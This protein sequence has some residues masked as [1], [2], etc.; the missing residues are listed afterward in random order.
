LVVG[1]LTEEEGVKAAIGEVLVHQQ[2]PIASTHHP[3][4]R[5]KLGAA[6]MVFFIGRNISIF[7]IYP[8]YP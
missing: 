8:V 3:R 4:K 2:F 6:A 7:P 1:F 5:N